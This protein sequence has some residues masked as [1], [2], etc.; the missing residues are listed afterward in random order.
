LELFENDLAT[1]IHKR[2]ES[3]KSFEEGE[4]WDLFEHIAAAGAF[5]E[6]KQCLVGNIRP[7]SIWITPTNEYKLVDQG[8]FGVRAENQITSYDKEA[9]LAYWAPE[10]FKNFR[11]ES[12]LKTSSYKADIFS[13]GMTLIETATL[14]SGLDCYEWD[15]F[16]FQEA[17]LAQHVAK[18]QEK[19]PRKLVE[20][21]QR[22]IAVNPDDR[23]SFAE[24]DGMRRKKVETITRKEEVVKKSAEK[25]KSHAPTVTPKKEPLVVEAKP[26]LDP[27]L[28]ERIRASVNQTEAT[29]ERCSP[30]KYKKVVYDD[31][32]P[33]YLQDPNFHQNLQE[34]FDALSPSITSLPPK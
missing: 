28:D 27:S 7:S 26:I 5:L 13:L 9:R 29:L 3:K 16:V 2:A 8:I 22:M 1:E 6:T 32:L 23:P 21:I 18:L 10:T 19:Y 11:M 15:E 12:K 31:I 30:G 25:V 34:A 24:L 20:I 17:H 4:I 14:E 33:N